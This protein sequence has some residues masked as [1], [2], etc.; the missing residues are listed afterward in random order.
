MVDT[1]KLKTAITDSGMKRTA[2]A[3]RLGISLHAFTNKVNNKSEFKVPEV[4]KLE[5]ILSLNEA[6]TREIFFAPCGDFNSTGGS[7]G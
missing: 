7:N 4:L 6:K 1:E 3:Q 2:I 5:T